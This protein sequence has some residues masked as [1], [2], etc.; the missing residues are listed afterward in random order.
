MV[1]KLSRRDFAFLFI[2]AIAALFAARI[3]FSQVLGAESQ[4][5]TVFQ[6]F[7]PMTAAFIGPALGLG[8]ILA[9]EVTNVILLGKSFSL[10]EVARL[11]PMLFAAYYFAKGKNPLGIALPLVC[12]AL[13]IAHPIGGQVWYFSLYWLIPVIAA[14]FPERLAG[15]ALGATFTAHAVGTVAYIYLFQST[16]A[17]WLALIPVVAF[18]RLLFASG[19]SISYVALNTLLAKVENKF[20]L[21]NL[22]IDRRYVLA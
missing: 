8:A 1:F 2:F 4:S 13:F 7:G 10:F 9:S 17:F 18:E 14:F 20:E 19:I 12:M 16:P 22:S 21:K 15:R 11:F 3:N 6:F 5:F